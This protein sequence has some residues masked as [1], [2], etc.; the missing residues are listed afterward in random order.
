MSPRFALTISR[1]S[2]ISTRQM[3]MIADLLL[4]PPTEP[5]A[6]FM[7]PAGAGDAE[8]VQIVGSFA[9]IRKVSE[10]IQKLLLEWFAGEWAAASE[11]RPV[12]P[13]VLSVSLSDGSPS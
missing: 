5:G 7:G 13:W 11:G 10:P 8:S 6:F 2:G 9:E 1:E 3:G 12:A 4:H